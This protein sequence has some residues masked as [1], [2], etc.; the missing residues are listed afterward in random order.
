MSERALSFHYVSAVSHV[1]N[2]IVKIDL[3]SQVWKKIRPAGFEKKIWEA[4]KGAMICGLHLEF[5]AFEK[6]PICHG[7]LFVVQ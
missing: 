2:K 7:C 5:D 1:S 3:L 6:H 4:A